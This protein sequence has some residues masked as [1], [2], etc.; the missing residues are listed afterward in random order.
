MC[1]AKEF[2]ASPPHQHKPG[3]LS[4]PGAS[5]WPPH[6]AVAPVTDYSVLD[7][8]RSSLPADCSAFRTSR[9][10][11]ATDLTRRPTLNALPRARIAPCPAHCAR[12]ARGSPR[13]TDR[14]VVQHFGTPPRLRIAPHPTLGCFLP[15][16]DCSALDALHST[17]LADCSVIDAWRSVTVYGSLRTLTLYALVF[18]TDCSVFRT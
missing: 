2:E 13:A 5:C 14:S 15:C 16:A 7:P 12:A 11:L 8:W 10:A 4:A 6:V 3:E 18:L 17:P 1:A 9:P